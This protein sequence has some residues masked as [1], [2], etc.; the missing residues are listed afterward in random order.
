M[1]ASRVTRLDPSFEL[2]PYCR[3]LCI[4]LGSGYELCPS[5]RDPTTVLIATP[6][7]GCIAVQRHG[8][9]LSFQASEWPVVNEAGFRRSFSRDLRASIGVGRDP[10]AVAPELRR[11]LLQP[12]AEAL[13][14]E[15]RNAANYRCLLVEVSA[16][17]EHSG[18]TPSDR[19]VVGRTLQASKPHGALDDGHSRIP[20]TSTTSITIQ[21]QSALATVEMR[22]LSLDEVEAV[23]GFLAD[24]IARRRPALRLTA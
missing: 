14:T 3:L 6:D 11:R 21:D 24:L 23:H 4:E 18:F 10:S 22:Y 16:C 19:H 8:Q 20:T 5:D 7:K 9:E 2:L 15:R 17:L 13:A 1:P 12:Y